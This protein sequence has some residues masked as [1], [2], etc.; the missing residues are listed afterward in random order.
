MNIIKKRPLSE[1]QN[2]ITK[3]E[4]EQNIS[5]L[6]IDAIEKE[7]TISDLDIRIIELEQKIGG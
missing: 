3:A 5:E 4:L 1:A 7:Q 2:D 6:E